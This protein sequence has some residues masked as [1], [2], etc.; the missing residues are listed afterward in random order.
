MSRVPC[1]DGKAFL[2]G[3][4]NHLTG[5]HSRVSLGGLAMFGIPLVSETPEGVIRW[6]SSGYCGSTDLIMQTKCTKTLCQRTDHDD[7]GTSPEI[8]LEAMAQYTPN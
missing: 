6:I 4:L 3:S 5:I 7:H 2:F 1:C 8:G